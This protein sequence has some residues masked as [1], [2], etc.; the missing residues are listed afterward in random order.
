M[1]VKNLSD[2]LR[3]MW[4]IAAKDIV[5]AIKN[6]TTISIIVGVAFLMLSGQALP[7]LL[8]LKSIPSVVVYDAGE[9]GLVAE[10]KKSDDL[11]LRAARSQQEMQDAVGAAAS[12]LL[13]LAIPANFDQ[14]LET[15][16]PVELAGYFV[17]WI[18][19]ADAA[20]VEI[21]FE[22]KLTQVVGKQVRINTKG[23]AVYPVPDGG[24]HPFMVAMSLVTAILTIC[25]AI[26]PFLMIEEKETHTL[27]AL[28]VSPASIG[29]VVAGKATAG[30]FYGL[31]AAGVV[32]AFN[33]RMVAHWEV[34]LLAALCGTLFAVAVGLL[35][36]S[37]FDNPGSMNLWF[38]AALVVLLMPMFLVNTLGANAPA[39]LRTIMSW[40]PSVLLIKVILISFSGSVPWGEVLKTDEAE[41]S[42]RYREL[43]E[44]EAGR[45]RTGASAF[46]D[47]GGLKPDR[48]CEL[49][50]ENPAARQDYVER[51]VT[52]FS[53]GCLDGLRVVFY[54]H[55][56]VSRRILP[57]MLRRLGAEV[58]E[59]GWSDTFVPVD[60][61]A[62]ENTD[63]LA[64]WVVGH[65]AHALV[66]ADG[67]GD[68]PLVVDETGKVVRGDVLG[69]LVADFLEADSVSV[70]VS[71][72]TALEKSARFRNVE[73]T[74]IGSPYVIASM[75]EAVRKGYRR[76]VGY[77]ANGGFLTATDL[78]RDEPARILTALPTR[79]AGL[80]IIALLV[81]SL[82]RGQPI[83]RLVSSLPARFTQSGLLRQVPSET[84]KAIVERVRQEGEGVVRNVFGDSLG[85]VEAM[86]FTDGARITFASGD[87]VHLRP[88]GNAPEF[89]CYTESSSET[90]ASELNHAALEKIR[91][92]LD[93]SLLP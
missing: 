54:Q 12:P 23:R 11:G 16:G 17:H 48:Q 85:P 20:E 82:H 93:T 63:R 57:E 29:Q 39:I 22:E 26:V 50:P 28:L 80:P 14:T 62:V 7:L 41:I 65:R 9:S 40:I 73:R 56:C 18:S 19:P 92:A 47:E 86:D 84:G 33:L 77:E 27:D 15:G 91:A 6:K 10:L 87:I 71:C 43:A 88:S 30:T 49:G 79:D 61:E 32:F 68:R 66:S 58:V 44:E 81:M 8:K 90:R 42:L 2:N 34:A 36:G 1:K 25:G 38:G 76:V 51:L 31:M 70:P 60:T 21:F 64:E 46:T 59:T 69:I 4:A 55:S 35:L 24:G 74:R 13:G 37:L 75:L 89:R 83:S 67:D 72:N 3:I 78:T 52:F 53:A 5:D 45:A